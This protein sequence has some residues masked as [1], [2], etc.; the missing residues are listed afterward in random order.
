MSSEV[1]MNFDDIWEEYKI[2]LKRFLLSKVDNQS[3]VEDLLQ[4]VLIKMLENVSIIRD[5][6]KIKPW[7]FQIANNTVIDF[8]RTKGRMH[9]LQNNINTRVDLMEFS[10]TENS[11]A[12]TYEELSDCLLPF[13]NA[14]PK[15][16]AILLMDVD[17]NKVQQKEYAEHLGISYS[18]LKSRVQ[19]S[20]KALRKLFE[21]CCNFELDKYGNVY[22]NN[23]K[24]GFSLKNASKY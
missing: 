1:A 13:I 10:V 24:K 11:K 12:K 7:L 18:T 22:D 20:R 3:D 16:E 9:Q 5:Q 23:R 6:T 8:Y 21:E 17:I 19:K 14:L 4:E 2:A 15:E